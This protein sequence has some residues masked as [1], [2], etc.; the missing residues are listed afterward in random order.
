MSNNDLAFNH[1]NF[2]HL[3]NEVEKYKALVLELT[4]RLN[5]QT[6]DYLDTGTGSNSKPKPRRKGSVTKATGGEG[7]S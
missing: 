1:A 3:I 4:T 6:Y 7:K 5:L 2:K